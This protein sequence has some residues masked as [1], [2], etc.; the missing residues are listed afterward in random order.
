MGFF[1]QVA[2][3]LFLKKK[4]PN[5]PKSSFLNSMHT[6]NKISLFMFIAAIIFLII[7]KFVLH[8]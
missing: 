4:D 5:A 3:Y 1:S 2:E 8:K 6:I 7:K